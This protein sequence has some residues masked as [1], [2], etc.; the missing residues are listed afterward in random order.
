MATKEERYNL[1]SGVSEFV[2]QGMG[3]YQTAGSGRHHV[4]V[5]AFEAK[6]C[7][8]LASDHTVRAREELIEKLTK[9]Q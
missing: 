7:T 5:E 2:N 3:L 9:E 6:V 1:D 4:I 8:N